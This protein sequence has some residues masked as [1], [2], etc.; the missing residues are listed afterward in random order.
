MEYCTQFYQE[1]D[2]CT[3]IYPIS[4]YL[5]ICTN[6]YRPIHMCVCVCVRMCL[7]VVC[8]N[9]SVCVCECVHAHTRARVCM[10]AP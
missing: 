1:A 3:Y 6:I 2:I 5:S 4:I 9:V 7:R 10:S 8:V